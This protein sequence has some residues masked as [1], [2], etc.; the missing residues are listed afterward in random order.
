MI[1][2]Q[3]EAMSVRFN[4]NCYG[5]PN[6]HEAK[7]ASDVVYW[8]LYTHNKLVFGL[9]AFT[10]IRMKDHTDSYNIKSPLVLVF[11]LPLISFC[12][13]LTFLDDFF[14]TALRWYFSLFLFS[15]S[16]THFSE[17]F[18][19][20]RFVLVFLSLPI[21]FVFNSLFWMISLLRISTSREM[22]R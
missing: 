21:F 2:H 7:S 22:K 3:N 6:A 17:W 15:L 1:P 4:R 9:C 16:F 8:I 18:L 12:L 14:I 11:P 10:T 13:L 20:Y 5:T 19:C